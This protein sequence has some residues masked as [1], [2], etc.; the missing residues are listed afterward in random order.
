MTVPVLPSLAGMTIPGNHRKN[1]WSTIKHDALS[2][3]KTRYPLWTY[4]LWTYDIPLNFLRSDAVNAELQ[5]LAGFVNSVLG[6]ASLWAFNDTV[7]PD[8]AVTAQAFGTG[9]GVTTGPFQLVRT[10]GGFTEPVFLLNGT[11]SIYVAGVLTAPASISAYGAVTFTSAPA[12]AAAL[13]WTGNFYWPCRFDNDELDYEQMFQLI[14]TTK[15]L[16]FT[17]E[18]LP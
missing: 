11:P 3:K 15:T 9:D 6:P 16:S 4:P 18:K 7:T 12:A 10:F 8:N 5:S 13:T 1:R 2:G 17:T 14:W